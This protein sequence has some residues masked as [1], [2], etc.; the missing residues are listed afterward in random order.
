[1]LASLARPSWAESPGVVHGAN[2]RSALDHEAMRS[3]ST[4]VYRAVERL[5]RRYRLVIEL[6]YWT[7]LTLADVA[8]ALD[9]PLET[10][11]ARARRALALLGE[12][13]GEEPR[14]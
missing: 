10:L 9:V 8:G 6:I 1:M 11:S 13:L 5:P 2:D 14:P 4:S 7:E 3:D 12:R